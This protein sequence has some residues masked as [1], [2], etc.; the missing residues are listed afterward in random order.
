MH[1]PLPSLPVLMSPGHHPLLQMATYG[2]IPSALPDKHCFGE[3]SAAIAVA[4]SPLAPASQPA[5]GAPA[6]QL[7]ANLVAG[8]AAV[9]AAAAPYTPHNPLLSVPHAVK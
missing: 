8:P 6:S 9:E 4:R 7:A 3:P 2:Y 1:S 5:A